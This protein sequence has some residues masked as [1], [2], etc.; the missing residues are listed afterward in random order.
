MCRLK[1][2]QKKT[3]KSGWLAL[4]GERQAWRPTP[5][6]EQ[7]LRLAGIGGMQD[8]DRFVIVGVICNS[9]HRRV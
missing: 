1:K 4:P 2:V 8:P 7:I 9:S 3:L 5:C 6:M